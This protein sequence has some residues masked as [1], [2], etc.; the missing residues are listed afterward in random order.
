MP[1]DKTTSWQDNSKPAP[2]AAAVIAPVFETTDYRVIVAQLSGPETTPPELRIRYIVTEK[3]VPVIAGYSGLR[4]EAIQ[5]CLGAQKLWEDCD[6]ALAAR[7]E[8]PAAKP[9]GMPAFPGFTRT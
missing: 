4:G 3:R 5:M 6:A 7:D 8:K 2:Q 9:P 1:V